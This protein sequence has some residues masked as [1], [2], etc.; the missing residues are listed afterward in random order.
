[1]YKASR[2]IPFSVIPHDNGKFVPFAEIIN[3]VPT[4]KIKQYPLYTYYRDV[5]NENLNRYS[6]NII[7][8]PSICT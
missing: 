4:I 7:I 5:V 2:V 8:D 1:V 3:L 6:I